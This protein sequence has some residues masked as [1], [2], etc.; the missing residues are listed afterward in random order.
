M[1]TTPNRQRKPSEEGYMLVAVMFMLAILMLSLTMA[2]PL[3]KID[4][5]RD[6][7]VELMHRG[8]Q[9][10]RA[11]KL[12]YKTIGTSPTN[13]DALVK[14][15]NIRFLRKKYV[16]LST[17]KEEW[18]VILV[19]QQKTPP[20]GFFGEPLG[21]AGA[22]GGAS[23]VAGATAFSSSTDT[24]SGTTS[25]SSSFGASPV[26]HGLVRAELWRADHGILAQ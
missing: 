21:T 13:V 15:N 8:K 16:D 9:Y 5:Q 14:T 7:D 19:G 12:Y 2:A 26:E 10:A 23:S 22:T 17:G 20:M 6:R 3:I 1:K 25:S 24:N 11:V 18:R 4:I